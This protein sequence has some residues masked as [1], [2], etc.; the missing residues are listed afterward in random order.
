MLL[1]FQK[2]FAKTGAARTHAGGP[3]EYFVD[4][5]AIAPFSD[6][7]EV[8]RSETQGRDA[9]M[10]AARA[11][12]FKDG[13]RMHRAGIFCDF[14]VGGDRR[15]LSQAL[16]ARATCPHE[17]A[18]DENATSATSPVFAA[19]EQRLQSRFL[20]QYGEK[21]FLGGRRKRLGLARN[22]KRSCRRRGSH[23]PLLPKGRPK[24]KGDADVPTAEIAAS[25]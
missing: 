1:L 2:C 14:L 18:I 4:G 16:Q 11:G 8:N 10:T 15:P 25:C 6:P 20:P 17:L 23:R 3:F 5:A 13:D 19:A 9:K 21:I 22:H 24:F 7:Y 12:A